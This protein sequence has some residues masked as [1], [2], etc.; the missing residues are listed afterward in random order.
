ML[1]DNGELRRRQ[2][3]SANKRVILGIT[4]DPPIRRYE[5]E[6]FRDVSQTTRG[7]RA[8]EELPQLD[9]GHLLKSG[10]AEDLLSISDRTGGG[11]R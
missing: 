5:V 6:A 7:E 4:D 10:S 3:Y 8:P 1:S 9:P 11:A 2:A